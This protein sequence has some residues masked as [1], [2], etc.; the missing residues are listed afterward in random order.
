MFS[1]CML[2]IAVGSASTLLMLRTIAVWNRA[3]LVTVPLV[4]AS[5]GHWAVLLRGVGAVRSS[6]DVV[7]GACTVNA[8]RPVFLDL[9]YIYSESK[10]LSQNFLFPLHEIF[11]TNDEYSDVI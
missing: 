8:V 10:E 11:G 5:L 6:W 9:L 3:P 4:V 7:T 1:Q 2:G